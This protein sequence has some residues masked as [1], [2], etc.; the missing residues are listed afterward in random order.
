[1]NNE[2]NIDMKALESPAAYFIKY[3]RDRN[4]DIITKSEWESLYFYCT[5]KYTFPGKS[6]VSLKTEDL[7]KLTD[8]LNLDFA[9]VTSLLKSCYRFAR[10][11]TK[12][13]S[14]RDLFDNGSVLN[15]ICEDNKVIF[16]IVNSLAKERIEEIMNKAKVLSDNSFRKN[17]F[18]VPVNQFLELVENEDK[19]ICNKL[20]DI[21]SSFKKPLG[22]ILGKENSS[23][24]KEIQDLIKKEKVKTGISSLL[25][26]ASSISSISGITVNSASL[27]VIGALPVFNKMKVG[28]NN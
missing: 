3:V 7:Y 17:L 12:K 1:M 18:I 27:A 16:G 23:K 20:E 10:E 25:T 4:I 11:E 21:S 28:K 26:L 24:L 5:I 6:L 14:F 13:M 15:P 2:I 9:K 8:I 19:E 22:E